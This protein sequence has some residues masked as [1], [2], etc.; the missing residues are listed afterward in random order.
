LVAGAGFVA[1]LRVRDAPMT[2]SALKRDP[3]CAR[4]KFPFVSSART[5]QDNNVRS[6][7]RNTGVG[8]LARRFILLLQRQNLSDI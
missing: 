8:F 6:A 7:S 4:V 2:R 3:E 5:A 1:Y